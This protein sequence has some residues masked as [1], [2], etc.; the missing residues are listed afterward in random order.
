MI[1]YLD[2]SALVKRYIAEAHS[3]EVRELIA[4]AEAVGTATISRAEVSAAFAR[5][6]RM[7]L[8]T[9]D[10][11]AAA[12]R[13]LD[14]DWENL[15]RVQVTEALVRRAAALAWEQALRGYDAVHLS[16]ALIWRETLS[17]PVSVAT[18][19]RQLWHGAKVSGLGA[20]P[21]VAP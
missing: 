5:A 17:E 16:A 15:I 3:D 19:D 18:F 1:V 13:A 20:W 2:A 9:P 11:A 14:A 21:A 12:L 4:S 6:A 7:A 10:E 8:V